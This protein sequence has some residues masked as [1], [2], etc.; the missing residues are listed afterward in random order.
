MLYIS[1][2]IY[3]VSRTEIE[4]RAVI[5]VLKKNIKSYCVNGIPLTYNGSPEIRSTDTTVTSVSLYEWYTDT[6]VT[7]LQWYQ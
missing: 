4:L 1:H 6:S 5:S 7:M 3:N 2:T